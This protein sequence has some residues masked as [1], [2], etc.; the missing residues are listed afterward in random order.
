[1]YQEIPGGRRTVSPHILRVTKPTASQSLLTDH[2]PSQ[3]GHHRSGPTRPLPLLPSRTRQ[4]TASVLN[5]VSRGGPHLQKNLPVILT[6]QK[7]CSFIVRAT[8]NLMFLAPKFR[9]PSWAPAAQIP[10]REGIQ[11]PEAGWLLTY[12]SRLNPFKEGMGSNLFSK[13]CC[14]TSLSSN[15]V[16]TTLQIHTH[17]TLI[18]SIFILCPFYIRAN[19]GMGRLAFLP[20]E[21]AELGFEP[22]QP[23]SG[24]CALTTTLTVWGPLRGLQGLFRRPVRP[25]LFPKNTKTLPFHPRPLKSV[26]WGSE[27]AASHVMPQLL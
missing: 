15:K 2:L 5:S 19:R 18:I 21:L 17:L 20:N 24:F 14:S 1:M 22:T 25:Q 16:L 3:T 13:H 12:L 26:W 8:K 7:I 11:K 10:V 6:R 9:S 27:E 23:G 4:M